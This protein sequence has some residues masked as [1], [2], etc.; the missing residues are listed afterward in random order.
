ML[1]VTY[2]FL[3]QCC[4]DLEK[5]RA[6][7]QHVLGFTVEEERKAS[8]QT[9]AKLLHVPWP[10]DLTVCW[11]RHGDLLLEFQDFATPKRRDAVD[12]RPLRA[13][14][15]FLSLEVRDLAATLA[16]AERHGG[17]V[18]Q[19]TNVGQ[20]CCIADPDGQAIKL[21][22]MRVYDGGGVSRAP[23]DQPPTNPAWPAI[24]YRHIAQMVPDLAAA[25]GFYEGLLG[26]ICVR[27]Y[28]S[29]SPLTAQQLG[30]REP[31]RL[32]IA[33]LRKE[34]LEL[35][36]MSPRGQQLEPAQ[37][38]QANRPGLNFLHLRVPDPAALTAAA[39]R[40]GGT[41]LEETNIGRACFVRD[42][43]GQVVN[44]VA[45]GTP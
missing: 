25:R 20:A 7:Y 29:T 19:H 3:A 16:L 37:V 40:Y 36:L 18:L 8:S 38:W 6:F 1:N 2:G 32:E 4:R 24:R 44:L 17:R 26:F 28:V 39:P 45:A 13:G 9:V 42:P 10:M 43:S 22:D 21:I 35:E 15:Q 5:T 31:M 11:M 41:A 33:V 23:A 30:A 34:G 27:A 12:W 14:L